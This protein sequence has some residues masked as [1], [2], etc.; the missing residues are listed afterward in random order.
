[1]LSSEKKLL[2]RHFRMARKNLTPEQRLN[3]TKRINRLLK[4]FIRKNKRIGVYWPIGF[5]LQLDIFNKTA[6]RRGA[7]LYL[8]YIEPHSLRLWFSPY[9]ENEA[10]MERKRGNSRLFIPQF[11]GKKI[12]A[13][14]LHI[15]LMPLVGIDRQ[16]YRLGQGGGYYDVSLSHTRY[17]LQPSTIGVGF[18]CQ[19]CESLPREKHDMPLK[20]FV[21]EQGVLH[22]KPKRVR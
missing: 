7:K 13:E 1:M 21:C 9:P 18:G 8:P 2:R 22:F 16:G 14:Q 10:A 12:R 17:R 3:A 4:P 6:V 5:E 11:Q 19:L 15:L 20:T